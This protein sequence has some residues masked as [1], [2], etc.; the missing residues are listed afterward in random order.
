MSTLCRQIA[1]GRVDTAQAGVDN[2]ERD[3][4][5]GGDPHEWSVSNIQYVLGTKAAKKKRGGHNSLGSDS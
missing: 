2:Q 4:A 3:A 5:K 1:R